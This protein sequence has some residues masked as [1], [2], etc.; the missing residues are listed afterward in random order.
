MN[1]RYGLIALITLFITACSKPLPESKLAYAGEWQSAEMRLLILVDGTVSYTRLQNGGTTSINAP[2]K[3]FL[4]DNFVVGLGP[5]STT[6]EVTKV[7]A[8]IN[9]TWQ[10]VVDGVRLSKVNRENF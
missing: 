8:E 9:G 7:P 10:M 1:I 6:F 4:D 2:I 3:G 5:F